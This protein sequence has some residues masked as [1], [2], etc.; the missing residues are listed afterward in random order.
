[1]CLFQKLG[2]KGEATSE[3]GGWCMKSSKEGSGNHMTDQNLVNA[4]IGFFEGWLLQKRIV[5]LQNHVSNCPSTYQ[6]INW[7]YLYFGR[8]YNAGVYCTTT[9][10]AKDLGNT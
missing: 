8:I 10:T 6:F 1:M 5:F 9:M 4:L 7:R 3:S 2:D